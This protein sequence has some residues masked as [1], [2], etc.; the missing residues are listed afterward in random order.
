MNLKIISVRIEVEEACGGNNWQ[1]AE[2]I[3]LGS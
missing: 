2:R 1:D 3:Y